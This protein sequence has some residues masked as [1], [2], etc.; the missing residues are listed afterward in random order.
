MKTNVF[1]TRGRETSTLSTYAAPEVLLHEFNVENGFA[2]SEGDIDGS[3]SDSWY[4][5]DEEIL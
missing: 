3:T 1:Q 2:A 4:K 5:N